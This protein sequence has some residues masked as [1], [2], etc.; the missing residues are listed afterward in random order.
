MLD[1]VWERCADRCADPELIEPDLADA[2]LAPDEK[3][4]LAAGPLRETPPSPREKPPPPPE[5]PPPPPR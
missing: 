4:P 3:L 1:R 2:P 5:K